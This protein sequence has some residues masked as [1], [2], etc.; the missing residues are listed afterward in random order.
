[1]NEDICILK[2]KIEEYNTGLIDKNELGKWAKQEYYNLLCGDFIIV[3]KL[4]A[5]KFVKTI[6]NINIEVNDMLDEY[7]TTEEEFLFINQVLSGEKNINYTGEVR[8]HKNVYKRFFLEERLVQYTRI[9]NIIGE[10][11]K[12]KLISE[13]NKIFLNS[14]ILSTIISNNTLIDILECQTFT[15][16]EKIFFEKEE[17]L[18]R[19]GFS[20]YVK[21]SEYS[22]DNV[23]DRIIKLLDCLL[24]NSIIGIN[25]LFEKGESETSIII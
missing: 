13:E 2:N 7:P 12:N 17:F 6:S 11:M 4:E 16:I 20:F 23:C 18:Y 10:Y 22:Q 25:I 8:I 24:G 3:S 21:R 19:K 9:K 5:F 1:M 15:L 14:I